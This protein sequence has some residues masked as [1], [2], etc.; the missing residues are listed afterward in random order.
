MVA[1][2]LKLFHAFVL[3]EKN[4]LV[5]RHQCVGRRTLFR[6]LYGTPLH[7]TYAHYGE[8]TPFPTP[9]SSLS[10]GLLD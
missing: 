6:I 2:Y 1:T 10:T 5:K 3:C 7:Y 4:P 8:E 9:S